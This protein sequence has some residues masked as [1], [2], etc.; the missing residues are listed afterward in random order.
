M[1]DV[2]EHLIDPLGAMKKISR[3]LNK[4]GF[5]Y[6]NTPNV[7]KYTSRLKLLFGRF[8]STSSKNEGLIREDNTPIDL[9]DEAH[10]HYFTYRSL[11]IMLKQYCGFSRTE[12]VTYFHDKRFFG[13]RIGHFL[14]KQ[15][16]GLFSELS[17][18][19]YVA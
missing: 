16:P 10:L 4:S 8:P 11:S 3:I 12:Y 2:I 1:L 9:Y 7:A 18:V 13:N 17:L 19:G 14:A 5:I 15:W 6:L